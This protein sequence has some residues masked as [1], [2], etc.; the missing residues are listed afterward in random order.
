MGSIM[1]MG[2]DQR[3][4]GSYLQTSGLHVVHVLNDLGP[5]GAEMGVIRLI[6]AL[7]GKAMQH[8]ICTL[9]KK[10]AFPDTTRDIPIYQLGLA[11]RSYTAFW[12]LFQLFRRHGADIVH[13]NNLAP[14]FDAALAA[15]MAGCVCVETFHGVEQGTLAFSPLKKM[16]FRWAGGL[17]HTV[18]AVAEP[19]ADLFVSL[20]GIERSRVQVIANGIDTEQ[21]CPAYGPEEKKRLRGREGLPT[22][23]VLFGCVAALRPVKNHRGLLQAC[24]RLAKEMEQDWGLV[25]IGDGMLE[26]E[27]QELAG[28]LE[29][30][31]KV[32]FL[33]ARADVP[34]L[35]RMLDVFVLNSN[36][37][38]LSYALLEA[39]ASA[40]PVLATRVGANPQL[41]TEGR[42]G[43]LVP[44][45]ASD[46]LAK[47]LKWFLGHPEN[48][49]SMGKKARKKIYGTY[50]FEAMTRSYENLYYQVY[51]EKGAV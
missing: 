13:V 32:H 43:F 27:L 20:T 21:F 40:L 19:A 25:L 31:H 47:G 17:S 6:Q 41:I 9:G 4:T 49:H 28:E 23:A 2:I 45:G 26:S 7:R 36:T 30:A 16:L 44:P 22:D 15:R 3:E 24:A 18:S 11:G 33:G 8:S 34:E 35:L 50:S 29:I 10:N 37:E 12:R 1:S 39:M 14:W 48:M 42:E 51:G 38:G 46:V 5:G